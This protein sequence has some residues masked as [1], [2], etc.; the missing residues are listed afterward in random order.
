MP[1]C[2]VAVA[3]VARQLVLRLHCISG[4]VAKPTNDSPVVLRRSLS[5]QLEQINQA[6]HWPEERRRRQASEFPLIMHQ[7]SNVTRPIC[8]SQ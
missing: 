8:T 1:H 7:I 3:P 5:Q 6:G 4:A 2:G